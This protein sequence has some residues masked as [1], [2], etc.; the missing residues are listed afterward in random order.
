MQLRGTAIKYREYISV[1][2]GRDMGFDSINA[3]E[4]KTSGESEGGVGGVQRC[5]GVQGGGSRVQG[6]A[7]VSGGLGGWLLPS[8]S[9]PPTPL[10]SRPAASL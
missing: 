10:R 3:F 9:T 5:V 7:G 8:R 4:I 1:G 2:K 6:S